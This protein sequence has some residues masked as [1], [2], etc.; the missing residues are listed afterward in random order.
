VCLYLPCASCA[1]WISQHGVSVILKPQLKSAYLGE[2]RLEFAHSHIVGETPLGTRRVDCFD[3]GH[4]I[5]PRLTTRVIPGT[6]DWILGGQDLVYRPDVRVCLETDTGEMILMSYRGIRRGSPE[7]MER[8]AKSLPV[9]PD[10]YYLRSLIQF[11][12]ASAQ[13][14]WLNELVAVGVGRRKPKVT[15]YDVFEIL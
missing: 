7:V 11:E 2:L 8:F 10:S 9:D 14:S 13:Y 3:S 1:G 4:F 15:S 12:T 5:G 6:S